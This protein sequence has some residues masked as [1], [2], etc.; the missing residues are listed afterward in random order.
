MEISI[1]KISNHILEALE[2]PKQFW[3]S[4]KHNSFSQS[5]LLFGVYFPVLL[6]A[7]VAVFAGEFFKSSSFFIGFALLKSLR[8]LL[9]FTFQYFIS[10]F[11]T[12]ELIKT[13]GGNKN[14]A[15]TQK[16]VIFS[17]LP[18][19]LVSVIS[20]L[21]PFLYILDMLGFYGFYIFW[22]GVKELLVFPDSRKS[23]NFILIAILANFF[24][25]GFLSI[26]LNKL[27]IAYL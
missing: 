22:L 19:L 9:L 13:F 1:K 11:L 6:L 15:I 23:G 4:Q 10:L 24:A 12:N 26:F 14:L 25:F 3:S 7:S 18:F 8:E 5:E 2:K 16:L 21:F 27:L 17:L 20:G